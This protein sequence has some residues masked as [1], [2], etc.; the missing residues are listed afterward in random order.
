[1]RTISY[2]VVGCVT[3]IIVLFTLITILFLKF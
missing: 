3:L 1:M 2:L